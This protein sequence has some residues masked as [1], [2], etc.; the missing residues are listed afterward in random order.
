M[1]AAQSEPLTARSRRH[2]GP[3]ESL[4]RQTSAPRAKYE[5]RADADACKA[6]A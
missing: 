1:K 6:A 2:H 5:F 3:T 4:T